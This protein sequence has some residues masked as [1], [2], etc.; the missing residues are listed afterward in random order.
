METKHSCRNY[1]LDVI[2]VVVFVRF[3]VVTIIYLTFS[4]FFCYDNF[5]NRPFSLYCQ[6]VVDDS[7]INKTLLFFND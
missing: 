3:I 6:P 5:V 4:S 1:P 2:A 7:K